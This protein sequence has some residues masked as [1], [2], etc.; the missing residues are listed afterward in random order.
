M[1]KCKELNL[2]T[3]CT[4]PNHPAGPLCPASKTGPGGLYKVCKYCKSNNH[5]P[6]LS[7]IENPR[8]HHMLM[9]F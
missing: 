7:K 8:P 3:Q 5:V 9:S 4:S 1:D 6:A 2:C